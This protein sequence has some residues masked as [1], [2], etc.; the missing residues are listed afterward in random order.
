MLFTITF[1]WMLAILGMIAVCL[2]TMPIASCITK[3]EG[4]EYCNPLWLYAHCPVNYFGAWFIAVILNILSWPAATWYWFYKL[5]T[6]G[7]R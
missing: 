7:R 5:C 2:L 4:V 1:E 6:A 3:S